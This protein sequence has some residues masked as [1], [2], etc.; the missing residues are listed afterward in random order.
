MHL[1]HFFSKG[2]RK[3]EKRLDQIVDII[4]QNGFVTVKYLC[5]Q[6]HYSSATINRD[7]NELKK[8]GIIKRNHTGAELLTPKFVPF[9]F[10]NEKNKHI[11]KLLSKHA[12]EYIMEKQ[13]IF[14]DGSTTLQYLGKYITEIPGLAVLTNLNLASFLSENKLSVFCLGGKVIEAPYVLGEGIAVLNAA[15]Y[16]IDTMFFSSLGVTSS[17]RIIG[18]R[19]QSM[20]YPALI[21]NSKKRIYLV[22]SSKVDYNG[23]LV[24]CDFSEIDV[25]ISDYKFSDEVKKNFPNTEFVEIESIEEK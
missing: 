11:K 5:E 15:F 13:F 23:P 16:N 6:L 1:T 24:I 14:I 8:A 3:N 18:G 2:V 4:K 19:N 21:K 17:G 10:R 7:L 9:V 20:L 25:V 22:D 12:A